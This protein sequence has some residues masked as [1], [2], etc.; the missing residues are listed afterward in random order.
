MSVVSQMTTT[1]VANVAKRLSINERRLLKC[2]KRG[3]LLKLK[4]IGNNGVCYSDRELA[5]LCCL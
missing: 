2:K 5:L 1:L 3:V 4:F